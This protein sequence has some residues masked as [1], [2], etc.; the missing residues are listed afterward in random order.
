MELCPLKGLLLL[1]SSMLLPTLLL[2]AGAGLLCRACSSWPAAAAAGKARPSLRAAGA[3]TLHT[4]H[5][6]ATQGFPIDR[7]P[8]SQFDT[9][10]CFATGSGISP[11]RALLESGALGKRK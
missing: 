6:A 2:G 9:V 8:A 7:I 4:S 5:P 10:L 1:P 3:V 11:I